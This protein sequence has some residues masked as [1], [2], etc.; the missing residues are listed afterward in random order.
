MKLR[1][2]AKKYGK[3]VMRKLRLIR[4]VCVDAALP[5]RTD[6][7]R[8]AEAPIATTGAERWSP[9]QCGILVCD[10]GVFRVKQMANASYNIFNNKDNRNWRIFAFANVARPLFR[11]RA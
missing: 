5:A 9:R 8:N 1:C 7:W 10:Y 3:N 2:W 4:T 6:S 11:V